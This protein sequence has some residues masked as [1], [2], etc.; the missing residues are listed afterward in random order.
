MTMQNEAMTVGMA[1]AA[2]LCFFIALIVEGLREQRRRQ[3]IRDAE[4]LRWAYSR[5]A[6]EWEQCERPE[7]V[8][9][10]RQMASGDPSREFMQRNRARYIDKALAPYR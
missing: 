6:F 1:V 7:L 9:A 4:T 2:I 3:A 5:A 10:F 8:K